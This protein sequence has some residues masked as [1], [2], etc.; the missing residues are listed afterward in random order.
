M[1][2]FVDR[3]STEDSWAKLIGFGSGTPVDN[4]FVAFQYKLTMDVYHGSGWDGTYRL[5]L[6]TG[7]GLAFDTSMDNAAKHQTG[8]AD[9]DTHCKTVMFTVGER[10]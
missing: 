9:P 7:S 2:V 3:T 5:S 10:R 8:T 6:G 4:F 1:S